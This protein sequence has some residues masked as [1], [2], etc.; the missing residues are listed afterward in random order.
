M[1]IITEIGFFS[2]VQKPGD[3]GLTVRAR[4]RGDLEA[5]KERY[6]PELGDIVEGA[7]TDYRFRAAVDREA[8]AQ[9]MARM[10][11]DIDYPNFKNRV[12]AKQGHARAGVYSKVWTTLLNL[13]EPI[14]KPT[15][16]KSTP[17]AKAIAFP[18]HL[19]PSY[20][21][22]VFDGT[23]RMLLR[24]PK[25]GFDSEG[26]TFPKGRPNAGEAPE[27]AACREVFEETGVHAAVIGKIPGSYAGTTT[28]NEYWLM[29]PIGKSATLKPDGE[30]EEVRW[31][32]PQEAKALISQKPTGA[33]RT[34]DQAVLEAALDLLNDATP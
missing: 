27:Q 12:A 18:S 10:A 8:L 23:G 15:K 16:A 26:W 33:K 29:K 31:A 20:G 7:G 13:P 22:V 28:V 1:W 21:G 14:S 24:T 6:L 3:S 2:I 17:A 25:G 32:S 11:R 19:K 4:V 30:T 9:A 5:L 34:R